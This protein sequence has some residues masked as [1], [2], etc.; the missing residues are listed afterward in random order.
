M[1]YSISLD[2]IK[3]CAKHFFQFWDIFI[4]ILLFL[5]EKKNTCNFELI[6]PRKK[7]QE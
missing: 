2:V 6:I 3:N 1:R 5:E 7:K 4:R